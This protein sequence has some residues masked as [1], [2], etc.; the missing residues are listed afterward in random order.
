METNALRAVRRAVLTAV[1]IAAILAV[2][3]PLLQGCGEENPAS[4][5]CTDCGSGDVYWDT[6]VDRCRDRDNGQFVKSC[7]CGH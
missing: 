3:S 6:S 5:S 7:C 1:L 4:A 2:V